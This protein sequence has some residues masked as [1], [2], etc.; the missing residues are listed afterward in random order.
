MPAVEKGPPQDRG[1][2]QSP[3]D[4]QSPRG[5]SRYASEEH[6]GRLPRIFILAAAVVLAAAAIMFWPRGG[7]EIPTGIGERVTVVTADDSSVTAD[8]T[9]R[10]G[11]VEISAEQT[12]FVPEKPRNAQPS[13]QPTSNK[14]KPATSSDRSTTSPPSPTPA[15]IVPSARG[16]GAVQV[17]DLGQEKNATALITKLT[18][19]GYPARLRAANTSSGDIVY[20]VWIGYFATRSVAAAFAEQNRAKIGDGNPVH[21]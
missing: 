13:K 20:R 9:P 3:P 19:L 1:P 5:R 7:G 12:Q 2:T 8:M 14:T 18:G 6:D 4:P 17:G 10:S 15:K 21:R 16:P 11:D